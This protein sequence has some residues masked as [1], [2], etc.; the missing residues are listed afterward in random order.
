MEDKICCV[1]WMWINASH[2][3]CFSCLIHA[4]EQPQHVS[5]KLAQSVS[6][7]THKWVNDV[8]NFYHSDPLKTPACHALSEILSCVIE[9]LTMLSLSFVHLQETGV[10]KTVNSF[11]KHEVAGEM[12]K[13]LVAQWKKL[14]PQSADRCVQLCLWHATG[15]RYVNYAFVPALIWNKDV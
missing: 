15:V 3:H 8:W 9:E 11:R 7:R 4:S 14:V 10:G 12:A 5:D 2:R 1:N 6:D 13:S